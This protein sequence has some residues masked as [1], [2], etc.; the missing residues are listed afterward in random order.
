MSSM[1]SSQG[2]GL[3]ITFD[4]L[5]TLTIAALDVRPQSEEER[6]DDFE[7]SLYCGCAESCSLVAQQEGPAS[8]NKNSNVNSGKSTSIHCFSQPIGVSD[9]S[10]T[11][12]IVPLGGMTTIM[13]CNLPCRIS[14]EDLAIAIDQLGFAGT[15]DLVYVPRG[16]NKHVGY[17]FINFCDPGSASS[18]SR[19]IASFSFT[20]ATTSRPVRVMPARTQGFLRTLESIMMGGNFRK[21]F[22]GPLIFFPARCH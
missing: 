7:D 9:H 16:V 12:L 15:Y 3:P 4:S 14:Q 10:R 19:H 13:L 11:S 17:G 6:A 2:Q 22:H 1:P 18:F 20:T 21:R 5:P 8:V